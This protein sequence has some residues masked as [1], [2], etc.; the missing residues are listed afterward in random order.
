M[1]LTVNNTYTYGIVHA[2]VYADY[3]RTPTRPT[4]LIESTYENEHS[5]S[6]VQIRRQAY[7]SVLRGGF[8]HVFG[9]TPVWWFA[10]NWQDGL[11]SP[12]A[13]GMT[14]FAAAFRDRRWWDL[15][16]EPAE[17]V[18]WNPSWQGRRLV[19]G[20][21]GE[22]RGLDFCA[23]AR[24]TDGRLAMLYLPTPRQLTLDLSLIS[25]E[26]ASVEWWDPMGGRVA[27]VDAVPARP[28]TVIDPPGNQDWLV[29]IE[30]VDG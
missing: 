22:S 30:A 6:E 8:G 10:G 23:G 21:L 24:T 16:P 29:S 20:G 17:G 28:D 7:W 4:F 1:S 9:S 27:R 25:G 5:A 3:I 14:N 2:N 13:R 11:E 12:G 19:V 15:V 18:V 26:R